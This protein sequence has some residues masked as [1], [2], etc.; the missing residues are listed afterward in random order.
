[1]PSTRFSAGMSIVRVCSTLDDTF[2]ELHWKVSL[3]NEKTD[4]VLIKRPTRR[5]SI[6][7]SSG[8]STVEPRPHV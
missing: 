2:A 6:Y 4:T 8:R 5:K 7:V 1:M 3:V